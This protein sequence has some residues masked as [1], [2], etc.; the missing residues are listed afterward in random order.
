MPKVTLSETEKICIAAVLMLGAGAIDSAYR[1][2][3]IGSKSKGEVF[4]KQALRWWNLPKVKAFAD[5]LRAIRLQ[6]AEAALETEG[7]AETTITRAFLIRELRLALKATNNPTERAN[8]AIKLA[9]LSG[10]KGKSEDKELSDRRKFYLPYVS[11]C[12]ACELMRVYLEAEK[13]AENQKQ[14]L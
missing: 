2:V 12:R 3:N 9:D 1:L 14:T 5:D 13:E 6:S 8:I 10:L 11:N 7:E 4:H